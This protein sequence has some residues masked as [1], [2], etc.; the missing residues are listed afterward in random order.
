MTMMFLRV[1]MRMRCQGGGGRGK[2]RGYR[3][4]NRRDGQLLILEKGDFLLRYDADLY[5]YLDT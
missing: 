5:G 3:S 2:S 1:E 4:G